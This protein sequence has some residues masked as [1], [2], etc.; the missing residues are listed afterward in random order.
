[1]LNEDYELFDRIVAAGSLSAAARNAGWSPAMVSKRLARLETRLGA[2]LIRRSTRHM[3]LTAIGAR[4]HQDV[5]AILQ[6]VKAAEARVAGRMSEPVGR[7]KITAPTSFGRL[8]VAPLLARFLTRF[9]RVEAEL[10]LS[11]DYV[12]LLRSKTDVAIRIT[13]APGRELVAVRLADSRRIL[14]AAPEYLTQHGVPRTTMELR[15]HQLLAARGQ[16]PWRL[17][18]GSRPVLISGD[19]FVTTNSSEAVR[20]LTLKGTGISLRSLWDV[21]MDLA[22]GRLVRVLP[23]LESQPDAG[24]FALRTKTTHPPAS[25]QVFIAEMAHYLNPVPWRDG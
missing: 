24:I 8:Y 11:D 10:N 6:S 21:S 5:I 17:V 7:L 22:H 20:E 9:P 18:R 4:F 19:S 23:D 14:C 13:N 1:M 12:D 3:E 15:G 2:Q 25:T 16:F